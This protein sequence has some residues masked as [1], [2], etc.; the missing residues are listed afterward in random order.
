MKVI[1]FNIDKNY[2]KRTIPV[3]KYKPAEISTGF[4]V[5]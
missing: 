3:K 4:K 1:S 5:Y 2:V